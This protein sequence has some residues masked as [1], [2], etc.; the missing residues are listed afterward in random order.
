MSRPAMAAAAPAAPAPPPFD[1]AVRTLALVV[2]RFGR[3][4]SVRAMETVARCVLN[5]LAAAGPGAALA[6]V[7]AEFGGGDARPEGSS[8]PAYAVALR[9]ARRALAGGPPGED[10]SGGATR[11]HRLGESPEWAAGL[12]PAATTAD[13]AFYM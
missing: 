12:S 9:I 4:D 11:L 6:A 1:D 5:R 8:D 3:A 10:P 7:V 13:L 2:W